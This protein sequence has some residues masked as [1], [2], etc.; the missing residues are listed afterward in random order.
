MAARE[1]ISGLVFKRA[2]QIEQREF[3]LDAQA[4]TALLTLD[5]KMSLAEV[6]GRLELDMDSLR[7]IMKR[8][9]QKGLIVR[10][11][12]S[13]APVPPSFMPLLKSELWKATGPIAEALL[14]DVLEDMKISA[15]RILSSQ[16]PELVEEVS[17]EIPDE[18]R[19]LAFIRV[20][21]TELQQ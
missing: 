5:G 2:Q 1:D 17:K 15:N 18:Q 20:M 8:L 7:G 12:K 9:A 13:K 3:S 19:R 4:L 10:V 14:E 16:A 6:A 21:L 11:D